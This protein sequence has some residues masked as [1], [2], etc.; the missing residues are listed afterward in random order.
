MP[1]VKPVHIIVKGKPTGMTEVVP[2][3]REQGRQ[4]AGGDVVRYRVPSYEVW[5]NKV[6]PFRAIRFGLR[7]KGTLEATRGVDAGLAQARVCYP[8][9]VPGYSPHS[10]RGTSRPGAWRL[11]P[12][13]NFLIHE[14]PGPGQNGGSIGCIEIL[15]G[16]WR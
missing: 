13:Q 16:M 12:G 14:G 6:G 11:I 1:T 4:V 15:D 2:Y 7:N 10:F 5:V 9:W 3:S 8:T